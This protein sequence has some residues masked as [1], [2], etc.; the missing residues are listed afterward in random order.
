[1]GEEPIFLTRAA[2]GLDR[3]GFTFADVEKMT[4]VGVIDPDEKFELIDGEIVP[5]NAEAMPHLSDEGTLGVGAQGREPA[6]R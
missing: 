6:R 5:M 3:R 2:E 4:A 1:M